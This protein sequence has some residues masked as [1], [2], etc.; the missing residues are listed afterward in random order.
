MPVLNI[1]EEEKAWRAR[2]PLIRWRKGRGKKISMVQLAERLGVTK[3]AVHYWTYGK[4]VPK[5]RSFHK[6]RIVTGITAD[7]WF[8]WL[9][10]KPSEG[11]ET[12]DSISAPKTGESGEP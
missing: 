3:A 5:S 6:L 12:C 2:C 7:A 9:D 10:A 8:R 11:V 1:S 4:V